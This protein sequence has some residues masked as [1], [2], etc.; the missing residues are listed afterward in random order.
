MALAD[1]IYEMAK[2]MGAAQ[3]HG[4][5]PSPGHSVLGDSAQVAASSGAPVLAAGPPPALPTQFAADMPATAPAPAI[6]PDLGVP[7]GSPAH[8]MLVAH[9]DNQAAQSAKAAQDARAFMG[10]GGPV[11]QLQTDAL[12]K[13]RQAGDI[14]QKATEKQGMAQAELDRQQGE[15]IAQQQRADDIRMRKRNAMV[16]EYQGRAD[17]LAEQAQNAEVR[18]FWADKSTGSRILGILAQTLSGAANGLAGN[19]G[20]PSPLDRIIDRDLEVQRANQQNKRLSADRAQNALAQVYNAFDH[21]DASVAAYRQAAA[22]WYASKSSELAAQFHTETAAA[23]NQKVQAQAEQVIA[24]SQAE[25]AK[26]AADSHD[27]LHLAA[28]DNRVQLERDASNERQV[29]AAR[30]DQFTESPG[31]DGPVRRSLAGSQWAKIS[32][33]FAGS[34]AQ[35]DRIQRLVNKPGVS[36]ADSL[37]AD[38]S[39]ALLKGDARGILG[40]GANLS[41]EEAKDLNALV[42]RYLRQKGVKSIGELGAPEANELIGTI[43]TSLARAWQSRVRSTFAGRD[44]ARNSGFES[45]YDAIK[46]EDASM[47]DQ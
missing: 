42:V 30:D 5:V 31:I 25:L 10:L 29:Q 38:A 1:R 16:R 33:Q 8:D 4:F 41:A 34:F 20:A 37:G 18:D 14:T 3:T 44:V 47:A 32:Q 36:L 28:D 45:A 21:E 35:I 2:T 11:D 46:A 15:E 12:D 19:P 17:V 13:L 24:K 9:F 22:K 7:L 43:R 26:V 40:T 23:E 6:Q 27:R 39:A